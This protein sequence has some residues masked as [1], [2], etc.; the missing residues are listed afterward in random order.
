MRKEMSI[1]PI[2]AASTLSRASLLWGAFYLALKGLIKIN[3]IATLETLPLE[4]G[5]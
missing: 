5:L 4:D 2:R 3:N 1:I